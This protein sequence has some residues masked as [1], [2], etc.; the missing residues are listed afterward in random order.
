MEKS[1][2]DQGLWSKD[3]GETLKSVKAVEDPL[4]GWRGIERCGL[5][6]VAEKTLEIHLEHE[7]R[8]TEKRRERNQDGTEVHVE[9]SE[10]WHS[11]LRS[12]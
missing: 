5:G 2:K 6:C 10:V 11:S 9:V 4:I 12:N 1:D 3:Y 7:R 8:Q